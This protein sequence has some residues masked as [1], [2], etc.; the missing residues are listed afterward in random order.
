MTTP[1]SAR[2]E[3][4]PTDS[5]RVYWDAAARGELWIQRGTSTGR[6]VFY[7]RAFSPF[8]LAD[9]LEWVRVSGR[10]T[11]DSYVISHRPAPGFVPPYV[12]AI[13]RLVEG[14]RMLSSIVGVEPIPENLVLDMPLR[15]EFERH[16][17]MS[18]PVF[19]PV[20]SAA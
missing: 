9:E 17:E 19:R 1:T 4:V 18:L 10:A 11:L 13:V 3:P 12:I 16:G 15:V 14:P 2:P 6:Y 8:G 5:S 7:P 20:E